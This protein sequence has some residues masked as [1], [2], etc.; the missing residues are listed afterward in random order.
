M[1]WNLQ[2]GK[3]IILI[4]HRSES[5]YRQWRDW[6]HFKLQK[7]EGTSWLEMRGVSLTTARNAL[8][9]EGL[10]SG[11][12]YFLWLDD[13]NIGPDNGLVT[14]L[15]Y[16]LPIVCGLYWA[17]KRKEERCLAAWMKAPGG[18]LPIAPEQQ[19]RLISVDV[20]GLGFALIHRNIFE[21]TSQPW[22]A[23]EVGGVSE[24]F[25]FYEKVAKELGIKPIIDRE[26]LVDHIGLFVHKGTGE[27]TTLEM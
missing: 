8:A 5:D 11:A 1:A 17:R 24:D 27:F 7:P 26:V 23:W 15:S 14:L 9:V 13:D 10:K 19:G 18:Y 22:F 6:F 12:E 3:T 16:N 20:T 4:V 21:R 25:H 2:K